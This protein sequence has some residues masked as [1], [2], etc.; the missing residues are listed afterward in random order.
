M[1][2]LGVTKL[3]ECPQCLE[4]F[5]FRCQRVEHIKTVHGGYKCNICDKKL[6]CES[7]YKGENVCSIVSIRSMYLSYNKTHAI[8]NVYLIS[9][10]SLFVQTIWTSTWV[11]NGMNAKNVMQSTPTG[12]LWIIID[13]KTVGKI[14]RWTRTTHVHS[15]I[16]NFIL[17]KNVKNTIIIW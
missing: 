12:I 1:P 6:D 5:E 7:R 2:F 3:Y 11:L 9:A 13:V 14:N 10:I 4:A 16:R 8:I 15:V 17:Q